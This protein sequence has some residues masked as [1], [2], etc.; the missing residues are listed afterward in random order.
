[1]VNGNDQIVTECVR[2]CVSM[3]CECSAAETINEADDSAKMNDY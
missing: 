3:Y 1:M 2:V